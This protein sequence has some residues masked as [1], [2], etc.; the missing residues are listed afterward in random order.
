[1]TLVGTYGA[2]IKIHTVQRN[3]FLLPLPCKEDTRVVEK[4]I[5]VLLLINGV[6]LLLIKRNKT[7]TITRIRELIDKRTTTTMSTRV[8]GERSPVSS[9]DG[10]PV[11]SN[12]VDVDGVGS[13]RSWLTRVFITFELLNSLPTTLAKFATKRGGK[14]MIIII[15]FMG[16]HPCLHY[17]SPICLY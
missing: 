14:R 16:L 15:Y 4:Y 11:G 13:C 2:A 6:Y 7:P 5:F 17:H 8:L 9:D 3:S 1:M 10:V 12:T